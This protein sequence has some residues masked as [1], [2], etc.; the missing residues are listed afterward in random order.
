MNQIWHHLISRLSSI[1]VKTVKYVISELIF[2]V[3]VVLLHLNL[4]AYFIFSQVGRH[5]HISQDGAAINLQASF[6]LQHSIK[7]KKDVSAF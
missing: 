6:V 4:N 5:L 2:I 7:Q 1:E 3:L